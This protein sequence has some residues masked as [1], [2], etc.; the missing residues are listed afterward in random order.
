MQLPLTRTVGWQCEG[1][2]INSVHEIKEREEKLIII[3]L[4]PSN[5]SEGLTY[6]IL[7]LTVPWTKHERWPRVWLLQFLRRIRLDQG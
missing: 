7:N 4:D 5:N 1:H 2:R 3:N 6:F